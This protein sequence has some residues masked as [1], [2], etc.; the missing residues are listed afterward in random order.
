[1]MRHNPSSP[2][3]IGLNDRKNEGQ[4]VWTD[5]QA[6][7]YANWLPGHVTHGSD[8]DCVALLPSNN[9]SWD[10]FSCGTSGFL[11]FERGER[12]H[13]LCEFAASQIL[14]GSILVG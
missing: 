4:F 7:N 5:G 11:G 8:E 3:W 13:P 10:D 2:V 9:G 12:H 1:M 6:V 14:H